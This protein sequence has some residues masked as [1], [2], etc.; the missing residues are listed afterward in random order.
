MTWD[1]LFESPLP[2]AERIAQGKALRKDC[3][4]TSHAG[5][6]EL[7]GRVS[8]VQLLKSQ[9]EGRVERIVPLRYARMSQN[10]FAF[11]RGAAL[12][13]A[14]DMANVPRTAITAQLCG[15]CHLS[16]FGIFATPERNIIFDLNDF[17]ETLPG[18]FEWDLKRLAAS[19]AVARPRVAEESVR[20]LMRVYKKKMQEFAYMKTLDV[21]YQRVDAEH[22][23]EKIKTQ[24]RSKSALHNIDEL[25]KKRSHAG[26]VTKFT[27]IQ[28]G[29]L[30]IK[31]DPPTIF[32]SDVATSEAVK[33]LLHG[34]LDSLW[35]SRQSLLK[36]YHY[37][38]VAM[39]VVGVG[40]V[41]TAAGIVLLQGQGGEDDHI[42]LQLKQATNSVLERFL[43]PSK[44]EHP[45]ARIVNG[46]RLLQSASDL[47]LGWGSGPLRAFY[48]RQLMD[49]K[50]SIP[51][52][53][54]D[55]QTITQYADICGWVLARAHAR[56]SDPALIH[57]YLGKSETFDDALVSF[58]LGYAAQNERDFTALTDA[59]AKR[60]VLTTA[61]T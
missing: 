14:S 57:G 36:K 21:W 51:I 23:M 48:I 58:A 13:F 5:W 33:Q 32:H 44:F 59:I 27:E 10:P 26:A 29:K 38:D 3:S 20:E 17:D 16:N 52:D 37:I 28:D 8:P 22:L 11:F 1:N 43:P 54:L 24:S 45:G 55:D 34:Y 50:V 4:R 39:K 12:V 40:S 35:P 30:R 56:T 19:F 6:K 61:S 53:D 49:A 46:Q 2:V 31:D 47:F 25:K 7:R 42:I 15:D 41:G 18:P 9:D 60:K